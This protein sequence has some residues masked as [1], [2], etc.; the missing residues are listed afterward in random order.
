MKG[1]QNVIPATYVTIGP[2]T[3]GDIFLPSGNVQIQV[4]STSTF[5]VGV[6]ILVSG[7]DNLFNK[8]EVSFTLNG[9]NAVT[10]NNEP[11]T[12]GWYRIQS[13]RTLSKNS[14]PIGT[15]IVSIQGAIL[16]PNGPLLY[17]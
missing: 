1:Y 13:M 15:T 2:L 12:G 4:S 17:P 7:F 6:D 10:G 3:S 5:D 16:N 11:P 14:Q 9:Q 8:R